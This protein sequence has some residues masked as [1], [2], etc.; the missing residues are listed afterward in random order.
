VLSRT[1]G[2]SSVRRAVKQTCSKY[3]DA[4]AEYASQWMRSL[5][6]WQANERRV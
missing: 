2:G 3:T 4:E 1:D 5:R 6:S